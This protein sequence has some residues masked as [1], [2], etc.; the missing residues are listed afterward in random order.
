VR[1]G[2]SPFEPTSASATDAGRKAAATT[3]DM[4]TVAAVGVQGGPSPLEPT[5]APATNAGRKAA[6]TTKEMATE[7]AA[8]VQVGPS[9]LEPTSA[10]AIDAERE[11]AVVGL[12][13]GAEAKTT[14]TT[15]ADTTTAAAASVRGGPSPLEPP[16]A[17]PTNGPV[18]GAG[19]EP[20]A[21]D[22]DEQQRDETPIP[23]TSTHRG[24]RSV[25]RVRCSYG[26]R[27]VSR[28]V[29]GTVFGPCVARRTV[30][31]TDLGFSNSIFDTEICLEAITHGNSNTCPIP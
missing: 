24:G 29:F 7:A 5:P 10:S 26:A 1:G 9:L 11:A 3:K 20:L 23:P 12:E 31:R 25:R 8:G 27:T 17:Q 2:P 6:A 19:H 21:G 22:G 30:R 14:D 16:F 28:T 13:A 18:R 15:T 4:A